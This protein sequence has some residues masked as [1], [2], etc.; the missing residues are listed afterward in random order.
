METVLFFPLHNGESF[1]FYVPF[2]VS[3]FSEKSVLDLFCCVFNCLFESLKRKFSA[4]VLLS[5]LNWALHWL[6]NRFIFNLQH[7]SV[8]VLALCTLT[9]E[10]QHD[11]SVHRWKREPI[12][13]MILAWLPIVLCNE[14]SQAFKCIFG[15]ILHD[16]VYGNRNFLKMFSSNSNKKSCAHNWKFV[17]ARCVALLSGQT[18]FF[19]VSNKLKQLFSFNFSSE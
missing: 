19:C 3:V 8:V 17:G 13:S 18:H 2:Y 10:P 4:A 6:W 11:W 12:N 5:C 1:P 9:V 14:S 16:I 15:R 7:Q